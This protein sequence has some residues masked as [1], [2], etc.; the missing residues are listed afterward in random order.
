LAAAV[1]VEVKVFMSM[2]WM[3]EELMVMGA[4]W[5][6]S[7][8]VWRLRVHSLYSFADMSMGDLDGPQQ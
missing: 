3:V 7:T 5:L 2:R 1:G 6:N 8:G 4:W